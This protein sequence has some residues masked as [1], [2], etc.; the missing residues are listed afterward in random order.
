LRHQPRTGRVHR[1]MQATDHR[2]DRYVQD[3]LGD[4]EHPLD[5]RVTAARDQHQS[6]AA[7]VDHQRLLGDGAQPEQHPGRG[8]STAPLTPPTWSACR[9]EITTAS[10]S[11]RSTSRR[12]A[13]RDSVERSRPPERPASACTA[14]GEQRRDRDSE[15][16]EGERLEHRVRVGVVIAAVTLGV[17]V[18]A[19]ATDRPWQSMAFF[20]LGATQLAVALG[21]RAR[22]GTRANPMLLVAVAA[23]ALQVAGLY[24]PVLNELLGTQ[25]V[26]SSTCW[27]SARC[28]ASA[29]SPSAST[30]SCTVGA[31]RGGR[32]R[33]PRPH[34]VSAGA[35]RAG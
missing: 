18:W 29:T 19:H 1:Q 33:S 23:L 11:L 4:A 31:V 32:A 16:A 21:S 10:R 28:Q 2:T 6:E 9:W 26:G 17:A 15:H 25:P 30:A 34:P 35:G 12:P 14:Q 20:A 22:P 3:H 24:L 13:L 7:N 5:R 27:P 8:G